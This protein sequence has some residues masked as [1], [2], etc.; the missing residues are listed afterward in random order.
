MSSMWWMPIYPKATGTKAVSRMLSSKRFINGELREQK[1]MIATVVRS[2]CARGVYR[3]SQPSP[4]CCA[5]PNPMNRSQQ[6]CLSD[7]NVK[8]VCSHASVRI[9]RGWKVAS[10]QWNWKIFHWSRYT[11]RHDCSYAIATVPKQSRQCRRIEI[12]WPML[13]H[14]ASGRQEVDQNLFKM[15]LL[16]I[17]I[18]KSFL[19]RKGS[20]VEYHC[21]MESLSIKR[22]GMAASV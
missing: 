3:Y 19:L 7:A 11:S 16:I 12:E 18:G 1:D 13:T 22:P 10:H 21:M 6:Y 17:K 14:A 9:R 20:D 15:I 4:W 2:I 5:W 8:I